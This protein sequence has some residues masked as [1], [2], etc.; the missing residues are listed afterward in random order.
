ML[1]LF[2]TLNLAARSLQTQ[3][4]GV[5]IA[6]QNLANVN[7]PGYSRQ[8]VVIQTGPAIQTGIGPQG[9]GANAVAI[10]QIT[11]A[12]LNGQI[13]NQTSAT[14]YWNANQGALESAQTALNEFLNSAQSTSGSTATASSGLS[15][16]LSSLFNAFQAVA[17]SPTSI[18]A[19]QAL[20]AQAQTL[21]GTLN[22]VNSRLGDLRT[23]LNSSLNNDVDSANQL[24]SGIADLNKQISSAEAGG[25]T[26]NNLRDAREQDLEN[27]SNLVNIQ[28][29]TGANGAV[30]VSVGGQTLVSGNQTQDTLQTYDAGGGQLLVR[31]A[32]GGADLTLTGGSLQG[33]IDARDGTLATMQTGVNTLATTLI[34]QV[35]ALHS[36]GFNLAGTSGNPN[37]FTGTDASNIAVNPS[38][39]DDPSLIQASGSATATG[40]NSVALSLAQLASATQPALNNQTLGN[41]YAQTVASLGN[42]LSNANNQ[43]ASQ[44]AVTSMLANQRASVS[45][46]NIDEEMTNLMMYQQAYQASANLV[47]TVNQMLITTLAM[48]TA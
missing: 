11:D 22:Q 28:T 23:S 20:I 21:A 6:G 13:Q 12:L 18:P 38:L 8:Q 30:N 39:A 10:Q 33:T 36:G 32:T 5:E 47:N 27:L 16:Q 9:T 7:T 1:G 48:K 4:A 40:D 17:T 41:D 35:N 26:A 44:T 19:R 24:L 29:S 34:T 37:F 25:G 15:G 46:V 42:A 14:G 2:G 45:G 31:T 3:M 43:V